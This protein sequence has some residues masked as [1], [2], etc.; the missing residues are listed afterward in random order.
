MLTPIHLA[1]NCAV[2]V[3]VPAAIG[4]DGAKEECGRAATLRILTEGPAVMLAGGA[5]WPA[6]LLARQ[7]GRASCRERV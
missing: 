6:Y 4:S 7:I 5:G 2:D 1:G 3:M